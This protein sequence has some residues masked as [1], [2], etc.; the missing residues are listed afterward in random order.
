MPNILLLSNN[1]HF[2][3]DLKTQI[4][5]NLKNFVVYLTE[6]KDILFDIIMLDEGSNHKATK[7]P[8]LNIK[9]PLS[10]NTLLNELQSVINRF[11]NSQEGFLEFN[12][13][14][15]R[16]SQKEILNKENNHLTKI[17]ELEVSILKYLYK[18]GNKITSKKD[19][20]QEVWGYN[21][22]ATT[23]TV[24]THIY[25]LRQKIEKNKAPQIIETLEGGYKLIF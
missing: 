3:E 17:T 15:L 18:V 14:E 25:R 7:I 10:L 13:Y 16:P 11:E 4:E 24:E 23:H 22:E 1:S 2:T 8:V 9:K 21:Q 5:L 12:C 20:L 6:D 19:L